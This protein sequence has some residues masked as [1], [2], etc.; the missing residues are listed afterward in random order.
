[1][2]DRACADTGGVIRLGARALTLL[3]ALVLTTL[4]A[5]SDPL[6]AF[7]CDCARIS[8]ARALRQADTVF[9]GTVVSTD[10]VGRGKEART[11]LRFRVDAVYKGTAY[12][13]QVVATTRVEPSCGLAAEVD[14][15][16]VVFALEG[17][18]GTG[19]EA[20][21][22]LITSTCSGNLA[23]AGAPALLG[24]SRPPLPG[25]SDRE[26]RSTNVDRSLTSGL[27][28]AG[29]V[30]LLLVVLGGAGLAWVWRPR[31]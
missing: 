9:H 5:W 17:I 18:E 27:K 31:R 28:A 12:A 16:W 4:G 7:A 10:D 29:V 8:T 6:P 26:E 23:S 30:G 25:Q 19:D 24:R 21:S 2:F 14:S 1:V 15:T 20:V 3:A 13:E 11:D 22:R